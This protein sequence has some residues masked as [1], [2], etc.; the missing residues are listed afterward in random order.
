MALLLILLVG[1]SAAPTS[2]VGAWAE[3]VAE[4]QRNATSDFEREVLADGEVDRAEYEEAVDRYIECMQGAGVSISKTDMG[5]YFGYD[6]VGDTTLFDQ[7]DPE[8]SKGTKGLI[9]SLYVD[10][11]MNP[12]NRPIQDVMAECLV[13]IG[14]APEGFNGEDVREIEASGGFNEAGEGTPWE[15]YDLDPMQN[16]KV[17]DCLRSPATTG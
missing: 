14:A 10:M 5:P 12:E 2:P 1:C 3:E 17:V 9:E 8:C 16:P 6:L 15:D 13:R 7:V 11:Y 4:A